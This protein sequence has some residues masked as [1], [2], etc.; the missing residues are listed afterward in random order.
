VG[1]EK[2]PTMVAVAIPVVSLGLPILDVALT[3]VRRFVA[4]KPLFDGDRQH[5]HHKLLRRGLNQRDAVL[6]LYAVTAGFGFLSLILLHNRTTVGLVLA[7]LGT[8]IFVGVQQLRYQEFSELASLFRRAV[9][10][11]KILANNVAVRHAVESL[12]KCDEFSSICRT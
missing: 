9:Q 11:R 12:G 1:S 8:G 4:G 5:I 3:V 10:R 2:A 6:T 7:V